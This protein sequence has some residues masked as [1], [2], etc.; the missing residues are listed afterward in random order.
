MF[1]KYYCMLFLS[2]FIFREASIIH[3]YIY[4]SSV[5]TKYLMYAQINVYA[6]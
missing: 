3:V 6:E 1:K 5:Y 4:I 2:C